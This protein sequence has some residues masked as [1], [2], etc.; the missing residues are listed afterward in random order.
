MPG[1]AP[2]GSSTDAPHCYRHPNRETWIRCQRC[3][4]PICPD[5]MNEASVGYQCPEC[6]RAGRRTVRQGLGRFGGRPSSSPH[7]STITLIG[8][9][10]AVWLAIL[11]T[12]G[13]SSRLVDLLA[14]RPNGLCVRG[15]AGF[16]TTQAIC[17]GNGQWMPGVADGAWWQLLTSVFT[18]VELLHIGFNMLALW[19]LGPPLEAV[20]G[21]VRFLAVY[22]ASGLLGSAAVMLWAPRFGETLGASGAIFGVM[23]ALIVVGLKL[24]APMQQLW[25]WLGLNLLFTFTASGISWQGHLG[26]LVGGAAVAAGLVLPGRRLRTPVQ[27]ASVAGVVVLA[28]ALT[29]V[30]VSALG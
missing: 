18:H 19:F 17:Q 22:L 30:R 20:L 9:N 16:D 7:Q 3:N 29:A 5:C 26:G 2:G 21:R 11:A 25:F 13:G 28:L 1:G 14:L 27:V 8:I 6:V 12:G 24:H 15:N 4:R 10:V 23:G